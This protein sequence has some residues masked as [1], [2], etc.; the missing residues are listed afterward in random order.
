VL[1]NS[2]MAPP[3]ERLLP[4]GLIGSAGAGKS[5]LA[6]SLCR[7][8]PRKGGGGAAVDVPG[9][10]SAR[11]V[12]FEASAAPVA[13]LWSCALCVYD[14]RSAASIALAT[15]AAKTLRAACLPTALARPTALNFFLSRARAPPSRR[16]RGAAQV[17]NFAD[18]VVRL[19]AE[20]TLAPSGRHIFQIPGGIDVGAVPVA[21][22]LDVVAAAAC[23]SASASYD[24]GDD[25]RAAPVHDHEHPEDVATLVEATTAAEAAADAVEG[26]GAPAPPDDEPASATARALWALA[27]ALAAPIVPPPPPEP[28]P[29]VAEGHDGVPSDCIEILR[30][31]GKVLTSLHVTDAPAEVQVANLLK[32]S[33]KR[34][35]TKSQARDLEGVLRKVVADRRAAKAAVEKK[36]AAAKQRKAAARAGVPRRRP[37]AAAP[38]AAPTVRPA[39]A[40]PRTRS[41]PRRPP[42]AA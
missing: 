4:V 10:G 5:W 2:P 6:A 36:A 19:D 20:M 23:G 3:S 31:D 15:K 34:L 32:T 18:A 39:A 35:L 9:G 37:K 29:E 25:A 13:P 11:L 14:P 41:P 27:A 1:P 26:L 28:E 12:F 17:C 21:L 42:K 30:E 33:P 38:K 8:R 22:W 16:N 7:V 40:R 24:A